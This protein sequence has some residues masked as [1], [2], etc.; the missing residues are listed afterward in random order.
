MRS[1]VTAEG[2]GQDVHPLPFTFPFIVG[3]GRSG[4]T[5]L[6]SMLNAHRDLAVVHESRFVGWMA[7]HRGRYEGSGTFRTELFLGDLLDE[8]S[9]IPSRFGAWGVSPGT[10]RSAVADAAPADLAG[11]VRV[12][13]ETYAAHHC[14]P[15]YADKTA[16]Y[17]ESMTVLGELLPEARFIHIVRDGRDVALSMLGVDFGGVNVPH[18]AWLWSRRVRAAHRAGA[19]LGSS[20]YLVIRYEDLVD[21]PARVLGDACDFLGLAFD[22]GMLS[23]FQDPDR[24]TQGL[25][26]QRHHAHLKL[27]VTIGLRDWRA[28]MGTTDVRRFESIAGDVLSEFDYKLDHRVGHPSPLTR[29]LVA[30]GCGVAAWQARQ[31]VRL[32]R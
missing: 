6:R 4:T 29:A 8:G 12:L 9:E 32:Q 24:V 19:A 23:Y 26:R 21:Q 25:G 16:G 5:L 28:Q 18:A 1:D 30:M 31:R 22:P 27:P 13:Y 10:I 17:I 15:M 2:D 20:R 14:K 3:V 11:A 7:Q